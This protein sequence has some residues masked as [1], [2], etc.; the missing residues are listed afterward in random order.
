MLSLLFRDKVSRDS[1]LVLQLGI[2]LLE[3]QRRVEDMQLRIEWSLVSVH[4][5][6]R[7]GTGARGDEAD[8]GLL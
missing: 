1:L 2:L 8:L 6:G 4:L 3:V 5:D 7:K